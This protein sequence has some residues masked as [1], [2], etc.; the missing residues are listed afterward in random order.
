MSSCDSQENIKD[1][2]EHISDISFTED[3]ITL[4]QQR[5]D[6]GYDLYHDSM[7]VA[8]LQQEHPEALPSS[9]SFNDSMELQNSSY[10]DEA[11]EFQSQDAS[12]SKVCVLSEVSDP[13]TEAEKPSDIHVTSNSVSKSLSQTRVLLSQ[14]SE[15][16]THPK[17][18]EKGKGKKSTACVLTSA[19]SLA[20][21][22]EKEKKKKEEEEAKAMRKQ[23][24]ER[25]RKEKEAE[26]QRKAEIR[27][28]REEEKAKRPGKS[29]KSTK[30]KATVTVRVAP[31]EHDHASSD[32][33][34][35]EDG[36]QNNE[37]STDECA[38]CFG[39]YQD[40]LSTTGKLLREWVECTNGGCKKWMHSE[41][42]ELK[43]GLY[44]CTI[45]GATFS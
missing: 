25:K 24:R 22:I 10:A 42:L 33:D 30:A 26:K 38:V 39:L 21:L 28:Q 34:I 20:A 19:E 8:W 11:M 9:S 37:I 14:L 6:N 4:F 1:F 12:T 18:I 43:S 15:F 32:S 23:E 29:S 2:E 7:Y 36:I 27:K 44:S 35:A 31:E 16:L 40:D 3:Q 41:C 5:F 13:S 17:E 45:C